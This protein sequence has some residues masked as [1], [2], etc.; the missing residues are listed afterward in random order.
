[1]RLQSGRPFMRTFSRLILVITFLTSPAFA[2]PLADK[3]PANSLFYFGWRGSE[4]LGAGYA[5]SH[6]KAVLDQSNIPAVFNDMIPRAVL[7]VERA[8]PQIGNVLRSITNVAG[9]MWR[10]P[11]AFFVADFAFQDK[12]PEVMPHIGVLCQ[13]GNDAQQILGELQKLV[14]QMPPNRNVP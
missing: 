6:L 12:D 11:C 3:V 14:E 2:Q 4:D 1:V 8:N 10:H 13:A 9:P 7:R 5:D